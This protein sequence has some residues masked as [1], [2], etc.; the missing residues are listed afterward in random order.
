MSDP[1]AQALQEAAEDLALVRRQ[2]AAMGI[3]LAGACA[4]LGDQLA[5]QEKARRAASS[6][7]RK[8]SKAI[9]A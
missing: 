4:V 3:L 9:P 1:Q 2:L 7:A 6:A 8:A 5:A